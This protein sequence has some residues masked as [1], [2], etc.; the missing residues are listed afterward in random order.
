MTELLVRD[1]ILLPD[2]LIIISSL[3]AQMDKLK[4]EEYIKNLLLSISKFCCDT[5]LN[6]TSRFSSGQVKFWVPR[7][8][9]QV[10]VNS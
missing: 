7:P 10:Q 3:L 9:G 8:V 1:E 5:N 4:Y 2:K 6:L